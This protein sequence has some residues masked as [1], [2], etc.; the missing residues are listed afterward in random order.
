MIAPLFL[1]FILGMIEVSRGIMVQQ[2]L[3][4]A[5]REGARAAILDDATFTGVQTTVLDYLEDSGISGATVTLDPNPP[6][7]AAPQQPI[8]AT[9]SVPAGNIKWIAAGMFLS[10]SANLSA[11]AT[12]RREGL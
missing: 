12:M 10:D 4:N 7:N 9:V 5:A 6:S 3:V 11:V 2:T 8:T 1:L